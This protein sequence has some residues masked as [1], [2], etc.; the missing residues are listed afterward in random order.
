MRVYVCFVCACASL[1]FCFIFVKAKKFLKFL[2][3]AIIYG[4]FTYIVYGDK[5]G[6]QLDILTLV[7][8]AGHWVRISAN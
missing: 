1:Y 3:I 4:R 8:R 5:N 2:Q 6:G 7:A